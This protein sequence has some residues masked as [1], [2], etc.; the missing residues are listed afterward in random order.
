LILD[1]KNKQFKF[2]QRAIN[3]STNGIVITSS[4]DDKPIIYVNKG[5]ERITGYS[6][7]EVIGKSCRF[8]Q[9]KE[10]NQKGVKKIRLAL[11]NQE[12]IRTVVKNFRKNGDAF[13][14][15]IYISPVYDDDN[16]L[17]HFIGVQNDITN[18]YQTEQDLADKTK[19][20]EA[21]SNKLQQINHLKHINCDDIQ[22]IL[23]YYI[24]KTCQILKMEVGV[25]S[26]LIGDNFVTV[27]SYCRT[28]EKSLFIKDNNNKIITYL[29]RKIVL[30]KSSIV[31]NY[32]NLSMFEDN[33]NQ[34]FIDKLKL[35]NYLATPIIINQKIY[36]IIHLFSQDKNHLDYTYKQDLIEAIAQILSQTILANEAELEREQINIALQESQ[37]KLDSIFTSLEDVIWSIHPET[38]QLIYINQ[39]AKYLYQCQLS[40]FYEEK[41]FWLN[42]VN[43]QQR[44]YIRGLYADIFNISLLN[45]EIKSHDLEYQIV[46]R[47]GDKKYVRDRAYVV[48]DSEGNRIRIDG[49]I[50]DITTNKITQLA[51]EK[52]EQE[53]R[54]LFESA[55]IG[56]LITD[57]EGRILEVNDS[58]FQLLEYQKS[59]LSQ[60]YFSS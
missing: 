28:E 54:I 21:F 29:S 25:I 49:I 40:E 23:D 52:S 13:W 38:L 26:E 7:Q 17:T 53:F 5:F 45:Q 43:L 31:Y 3:S 57:I 2:L 36:G 15:E 60:K 56:M 10:R 55:S 27:S 46:L 37:D 20:L 33:D 16:N 24:K 12:E 9:R 18:Q 39:S 41:Y 59:E 19:Q 8:L 48:Y 6:S 4:L 1:S 47:N 30:E 32:N 35:Q 42:F 58:L 14:N 50:T 11:A 44:E 22:A 34:S 51:L